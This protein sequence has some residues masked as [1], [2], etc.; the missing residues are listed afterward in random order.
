MHTACISWRDRYVIHQDLFN[1]AVTVG[2]NTL[3]TS[4]CHPLPLVITAVGKLSALTNYIRLCDIFMIFYGAQLHTKTLH[5]ALSLPWLPKMCEIIVSL[6]VL[7]WQHCLYEW[8]HNQQLSTLNKPLSTSGK[9]SL[10]KQWVEVRRR[11]IWRTGCVGEFKRNRN[12][13]Q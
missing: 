2:R 3:I 4:K 13:V 12:W 11:L 8:S 9:L 1:L 10:E 5:F 6:Q 7:P